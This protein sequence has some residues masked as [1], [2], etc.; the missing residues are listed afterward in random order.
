MDEVL[1]DLQTKDRRYALAHDAASRQPWVL[2][3]DRRQFR[4]DLE[5][6]LTAARRTLD[7]MARQL[8]TPEVQQ[9]YGKLLVQVKLAAASLAEPS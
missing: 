9:R 2:A 5:T 4:H 6:A 8:R 7:A 1:E 3:E